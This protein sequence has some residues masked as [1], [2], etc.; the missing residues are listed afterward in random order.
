MLKKYQVLAL[1]LVLLSLGLNACKESKKDKISNQNNIT[2]NSSSEIPT[3]KKLNY[4][5]ELQQFS[6]NTAKDLKLLSGLSLAY[7]ETDQLRFRLTPEQNGY[8]YLVRES[9]DLMDKEKQIPK[10]NWVFPQSKIN[11]FIKATEEN[12]LPNLEQPPLDF[13][14]IKEKEKLWLI[15]SDKKLMGLEMVKISLDRGE[16]QEIVKGNEI[17]DLELATSLKN[18]LEKYA[19]NKND[20]VKLN[21][22]RKG[23]VTN[24]TTSENIMTVAIDLE[25][26]K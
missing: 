26:I 8:V 11:N 1:I 24:L 19:G 21:D 12:K 5:I 9:S 23:R 13:S 22:D 17:I 25:K 10:Y 6:D 3:I 4:S 15:W 20:K 16:E 7:K 2:E 14:Q 18:M